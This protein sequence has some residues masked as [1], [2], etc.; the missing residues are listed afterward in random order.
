[1]EREL[2][3]EQGEAPQVEDN[4]TTPPL[5]EAP[6]SQDS[7]AGEQGEQSADSSTD[8]SGHGSAI[9]DAVTTLA[10]QAQRT[11]ERLLRS[12]ADFE[13]YRKRARRE[14][15]TA[16]AQAEQQIVLE[17]L[18]VLDNLERAVSHAEE[19]SDTSA[20]TRN[21][22]DGVKMVQ[23]QFL[24]TL[25]K[26]DIEPLESV[27][28]AFDPEFHEALQQMDSELPKNT[29][30]VEV[31]KGYVR[32]SRLVRPALVIVSKGGGTTDRAP[33]QED[34]AAQRA[35]EAVNGETPSTSSGER[36]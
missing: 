22:L 33:A 5:A 19:K 10:Q 1:M 13:N 35:A 30:V 21:L 17:F 18:P 29:I 12:T 32:N 28:K 25:A 2:K 23:K 4:E 7:A 20:E 27:G 16:V 36:S 24:T 31:Q 15:A 11:H 26:H 3:A 14:L 9:C 8:T 6:D 34:Q